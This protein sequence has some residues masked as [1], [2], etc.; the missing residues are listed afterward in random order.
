M[1]EMNSFFDGFIHSPD[2][3]IPDH[4]VNLHSNNR[5]PDSSVGIWNT[6]NKYDSINE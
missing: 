6:L 1:N 3:K 2:I 4:F 5:K